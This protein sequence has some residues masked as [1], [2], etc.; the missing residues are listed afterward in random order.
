MPSSPLKIIKVTGPLGVGKHAVV[1]AAAG[2]L[3]ERNFFLDGAFLI[4]FDPSLS[5][6][7]HIAKYVD[8]DIKN[9]EDL[10]KKLKSS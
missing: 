10:I 2:Y 3:V 7:E 6:F 5:C 9:E 1:K 8:P 4:K